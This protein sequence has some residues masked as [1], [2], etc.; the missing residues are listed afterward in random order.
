MMMQMP[1]RICFSIG[2][3]NVYWYGVLM[4]TGIVVAI[5]L[6]MQEAKRKKLYADAIIDACLIMIPMGVIGARLYYVLFE[7]ETYAANPISAL[8]IWQ[9]GLAMYGS[10]IGGL[11][12]LFIFSRWKKIR[13]SKMTDCIAPGLVLAQAIGRWGNFFN[14]EAFGLPVTQAM[15]ERFSLLRFFP[16][17][18]YIE[19]PHSFDGVFCTNPVHLATFF[20][21]SVWC[22]LVAVILW[23]NRKK[24]KH[25]GDCFLTYLLLYAFERMFVEG[26]R[27]D[28]LYLLQ[29]SGAF[30]GVRVSQMLSFLAVAAI[31]LFFILRA[32]REK[33]EGRLMWP[34]PEIEAANG[35]G[36]SAADADTA[37]DEDASDETAAPDAEA[38]QPEASQDVQDAD[39]SQDEPNN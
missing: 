24:F 3:V 8:Y 37:T 17:S 2:P 18:V 12:G 4:A 25:D 38:A 5:L 14:Q 6:A 23:C 9:G 33:K 39:V 29:P 10:M 31:G 34:A 15:M 26:L 22:L 7:W 35:E 20:Y 30:A 16:L 13:F 11:L 21:E 36:E 19:G 27:G 32:A 28:S 1:D